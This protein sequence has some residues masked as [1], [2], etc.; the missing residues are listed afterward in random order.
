M[1]KKAKGFTIVEL[2]VVISV[3]AILLIGL[4][5]A[6]SGIRASSRDARRI[7]DLKNV[8]A[9]VEMYYLGEGHKYPPASTDT[10][11]DGVQGWS[12]LTQALEHPGGTSQPNKPAYMSVVPQ[13][14]VN[15]GTH[16]YAYTKTPT[17]YHLQAVLEVGNSEALNDDSPADNMKYD[18]G[19]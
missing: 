14:P 13:D 16:I 17:S 6:F 4:I 10:I 8:Q 18:L 1:T 2:L 9:A 12:Q 11:G 7:S 3:I 15:S 5:M 19:Q